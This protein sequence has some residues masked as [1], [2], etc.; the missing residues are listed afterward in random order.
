[1]TLNADSMALG[2]IVP[3]EVVI[4]ISGAP[5]PELGTMEFTADWATHTTSNDEFGYDKNYMVYC[6]FVD[7]ADPGLSGSEPKRKGPSRS[8]PNW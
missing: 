6:A 4:G 7:T 2:Q 1:M 5:G 8:A 3:F